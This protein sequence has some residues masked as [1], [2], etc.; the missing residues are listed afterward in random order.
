[1]FPVKP[2]QISD[3]SIKEKLN[4]IGIHSLE[5]LKFHG[6]KR[7]FAMLRIFD[8]NC[9]IDVLFFLESLIRNTTPALLDEE[10]ITDLKTFYNSISYF[11]QVQ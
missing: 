2:P 9:G 10:V 3:Q 11:K 7:A 4:Q 8:G 6:S 1:M 5:D